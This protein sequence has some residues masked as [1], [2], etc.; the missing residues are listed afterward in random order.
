MSMYEPENRKLDPEREYSIGVR[1]REGNLEKATQNIFTCEISPPQS[2][3]ANLD[4]AAEVIQRSGVL[5]NMRIDR[6][7]TSYNTASTVFRADFS[8]YDVIDDSEQRRMNIQG[9]VRTLLRE[10]FRPASG[11]DMY[12]EF[13]ETRSE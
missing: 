1:V 6:S 10:L 5:E 12:I 3:Q 2:P 13:L 7:V 11:A 8:L 9:S 4:A